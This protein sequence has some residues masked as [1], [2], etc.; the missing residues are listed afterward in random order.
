MST[1]VPAAAGRPRLQV[2]TGEAA[3]LDGE[4]AADHWNAA[5]LGIPAR[6]GRATARFDEIAQPWRWQASKNT[7]IIDSD[8]ARV[9]AEYPWVSSQDR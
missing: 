9:A 3:A 8:S 1:P 6:R 5:R 4:W 2:L 7:R